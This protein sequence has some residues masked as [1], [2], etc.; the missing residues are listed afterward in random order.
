[1]KVAEINYGIRGS[2]GSIM[3]NIADMVRQQGGEAVTFSAPKD[4]PAPKCHRYFGTKTENLVHRCFSVFTGISGT[5]SVRGTKALL[6]ELEVFQPDVLH[7]HNL[8]GWFINLPMLFD[9][10]RRHNI[11]TVWTLHDCWGFTAQCSHFSMEKCEKWKSGC[12]RCPRYRLYPYTYVDRTRKMWK[13]KKKW[14]SGVKDLTIVTPSQWLA[15]LVKQSF[16]GEYPVQV[17]HNGIDLS[18]FQPTESDFRQTYHIP[19]D[20]CILLGVASSWTYRKGLDVF[21]ELA[22]RL[23]PKAYQIVLVGTDDRFT[24]ELPENIL[25][26]HRTESPQELAKIY[27][28]ADLFINPTREEVLGLVNIEAL[29]CGTP[30]LTFDTG[31]SPECIDEICGSAVPCNDVDAL[32]YKI[33][34]IR[35]GNPFSAESCV[36]RAQNFDK[37][38]KFAQYVDLYRNEVEQR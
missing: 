9:F 19:E 21:A 22:N 8:H 5:G 16:L 24:R 10:I 3:L 12:Y 35:Q 13:L 6:A 26:F 34:Q 29:A 20:V 17:I 36:K 14:F 11:K 2:T 32:E 25:C 33:V 4:E 30:V 37:K 1:M 15:G 23:D 18:V 7:L 28:A 27:T 38:L 31:G